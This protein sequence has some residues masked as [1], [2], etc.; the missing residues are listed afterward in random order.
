MIRILGSGIRQSWGSLPHGLTVGKL[1]E[2]SGAGVI[3]VRMEL[4]KACNGH[5]LVQGLK[6][7]L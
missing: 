4:A 2:G 5:G 7:R 1:D 3:L 6:A